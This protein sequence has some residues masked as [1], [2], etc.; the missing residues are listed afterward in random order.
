MQIKTNPLTAELSFLSPN[1]RSQLMYIAKEKV[2]QYKG[3]APSSI[4]ICPVRTGRGYRGYD[5]ADHL[6]AIWEGFQ[7]D[8]GKVSAL[9][10]L[11]IE[12]NEPNQV[13]TRRYRSG[14]LVPARPYRSTSFG[15]HESTRGYLI[16]ENPWK[17]QGLFI[18]RKFDS[19]EEA[20]KAVRR[21]RGRWLFNGRS[22]VE[23]RLPLETTNLSALEQIT[24]VSSVLG[25]NLPKDQKKMIYDLYRSLMLADVDQKTSDELAGLEGILDFVRW[26]LFG[27][28]VN[29][30]ISEYYGLRDRSVMLAGVYGVG[31]TTIAK[32]LATENHSSLFI[33]IEALTLVESLFEKKG[34]EEKYTLFDAVKRL[35][36]R[37]GVDI[38]LFCDDIE[39]AM[40]DPKHHHMGPEYLAGTSSLLNK[41][42][43]IG[44]GNTL[45]NGS[46]NNPFV[47]DPRF[48]EFGRVGY[49]IHVPLPDEIG[50]LRT[51]EIHTRQR[52]I[53][54]KMDFQDLAKKTEGFSN[55]AIEEVCN[56]AGESALR[57]AARSIKKPGETEFDAAKRVTLDIAEDF[58]I[59]EEDFERGL[60]IVRRHI[61]T[62]QVRALDRDI[63]NFCEDYNSRTIGFNSK[64]R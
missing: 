33:P 59:R 24:R 37:T 28:S 11:M 60:T 62:D 40:I 16:S 17:N 29:P 4:A 15:V 36:G 64:P 1:Q 55:R 34:D 44:G 23:L 45:L 30:T 50:R 3:R 56:K 48:L 52:P 43:G 7:L 47:I 42:Q 5:T 27:G 2:S 57:R 21:E 39:S 54:R 9:E 12:V 53:K 61:R 58:P 26:T 20:T 35:Q 13:E 22:F 8:E 19:R 25:A 6:V 63:G 18:V 41:L 38:A 46:T 31:K 14:R 51:F 32:V 49:I 10:S